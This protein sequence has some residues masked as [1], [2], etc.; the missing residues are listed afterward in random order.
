MNA[1][2]SRDLKDAAQAKIL[3]GRLQSSQDHRLTNSDHRKISA[4]QSALADLMARIKH[5]VEV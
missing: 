3:L 1:K 2:D 4:A 5:D